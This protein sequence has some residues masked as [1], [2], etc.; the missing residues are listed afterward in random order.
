MSHVGLS[1]DSSGKRLQKSFP[2]NREFIDRLPRVRDNSL[3]ACGNCHRMR[4]CGCG[5]SAN[6][7]RAA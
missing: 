3:N 1:G 4:E 5:A 7:A 2:N 6:V